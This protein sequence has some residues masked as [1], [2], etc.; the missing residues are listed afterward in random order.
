MKSNFFSISGCF[1]VG[2]L[3]SN[4]TYLL[5]QYFW[6]CTIAAIAVAVSL[7]FPGE[8]EILRRWSSLAILGGM[9]A[10]NWETLGQISP[11][12]LG[13]GAIAIV[14]LVGIAVAIVGSI[15]GQRNG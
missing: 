15:G 5:P 12:Q 1:S 11:V 6:L 7:C 8:T 4:L 10:N 9:L 14:L 2:L 3:L 13:L